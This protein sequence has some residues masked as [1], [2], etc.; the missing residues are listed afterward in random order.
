MAGKKRWSDL[1]QWQKVATVVGGIVQFSLL[2]AALYD[3]QKRP[4]ERVKGSKKLW[5]GLVFINWVGPISYFVVGR[6]TS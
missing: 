6:R 5:R 3:L 4:A 1:K 2:V